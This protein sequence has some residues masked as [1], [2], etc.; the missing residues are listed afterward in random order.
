MTLDN[1]PGRV[2][3]LASSVSRLRGWVGSD[4]TRQVELAD[5]LVELTEA[6][7]E[8]NAWNDAAADAKESALL[9][10]RLLAGEGALGPYTGL[11]DAKRFVVASLQ[12]ADVQAGLG[13]AEPAGRTVATAQSVMD[14]LP[15]LELN[16]DGATLTRA[17]IALSIAAL[18]TGHAA[19]ANGYADAACTTSVRD[20]PA[21][22]MLRVL[23]LLSDCRWTAGRAQDSV[24]WALSAVHHYRAS[25]DL[26]DAAQ[27]HPVRLERLAEPLLVTYRTTADRLVATGDVEWGLTLGRE[28]IDQLRPLVPRVAPSQDWLGHAEAALA[29]DLRTAGRHYEAGRAV[30]NAQ[31]S[32]GFSP[33]ELRE[34]AAWARGR[35]APITDTIDQWPAPTGPF[36]PGFSVAAVVSR[37]A[38]AAAVFAAEAAIV[39]PAAERSEGEFRQAA[40]AAH[41]EQRAA[42]ADEARIAAE[43]KARAAAAAR[44]RQREAEREEEENRLAAEEADR[45]ETKRLRQ[46]RIE[47]HQ[48][49]AERLAAQEREAALISELSTVS[50]PAERER[51]ELELLEL[52]IARIEADTATPVTHDSD[53]APSVPPVRPGGPSEGLPEPTAHLA[54]EQ[55]TEAVEDA[56]PEPL[57]DVPAPADPLH[58]A[59]ETRDRARASGRRALRDATE[60]LVPLLRSQAETDPG[61]VRAELVDTLEELATLRR[62]SGDWLGSRAP[63]SEAKSLAKKWGIDRSEAR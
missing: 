63:A 45:R 31:A 47:T 16:L 18:G 29:E 54:V 48:R 7:L 14:Q 61:R 28:L 19:A 49:N 20:I 34:S 59:R 53:P 62:R 36:A 44:R 33:D 9:A 21:L 57:V 46:L 5:A 35:F 4:A 40:E 37:E 12:L 42:E 55:H 38:D 2:K 10:A 24:A 43:R 58:A 15:H 39:R 1:Y 6:R 3:Q 13:F 23:L 30:A 52:Q 41:A 60:L 26:G 25:V 51:V 50:D 11:E 8:A 22:V 32:T 17:N 27:I 56:P